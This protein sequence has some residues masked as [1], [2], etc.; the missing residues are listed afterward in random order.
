MKEGA[1][2]CSKRRRQRAAVDLCW[3]EVDELQMAHAIAEREGQELEE[4][5]TR[6]TSNEQQVGAVRPAERGGERGRGSNSRQLVCL[7]RPQVLQ[8]AE[9]EREVRGSSAQVV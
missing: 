8:T 4:R 7:R 5:D 3:R 2:S 6:A 9:R 1:N